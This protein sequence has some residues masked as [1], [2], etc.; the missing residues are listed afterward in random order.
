MEAELNQGANLEAIFI[1]RV[2]NE[3]AVEERNVRPK[4]AGS[5]SLGWGMSPKKEGELVEKAK[6]ELPL[7]TVPS[8]ALQSELSSSCVTLGRLLTLSKPWSPCL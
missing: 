3:F 1:E 2:G 5:R 4:R 6:G 8:Q 7:N